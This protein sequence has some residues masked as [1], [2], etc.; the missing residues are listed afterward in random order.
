MTLS[1]RGGQCPD[2]GV[3]LLGVMPAA[4]PLA[5][6]WKLTTVQLKIMHSLG[7]KMMVYT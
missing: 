5:A 1:G 7:K 4:W 2:K 3:V 6:A